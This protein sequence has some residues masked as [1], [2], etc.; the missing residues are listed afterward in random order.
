MTGTLD[1]RA[2]RRVLV[3]RIVGVYGV[4]GWV[5]I[6]SWTEPRM[7]IFDYRPW[8][9]KSGSGERRI[10]GAA[11]R[12][13][14]RG[15]VARLPGVGDRDQAAGLVGS[16]I[17]IARS[18]LPAPGEG[19]VYWADLEGCE[20]VT[21]DGV[22]LGRVSHLVATGANDVLVVRDGVR[23]RLIPHVRDEYVTE[24]DLVA[25]RITV[26]WDPEF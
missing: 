19:E 9:L 23:E 4:R 2:S 21:I 16:D 1:A 7:R 20:V 22:A 5:R 14:G 15:L 13:Q 24:I 12:E 3:G 10:D 6:E 8:W 25:G 17:G 26:D 11:G 18:A